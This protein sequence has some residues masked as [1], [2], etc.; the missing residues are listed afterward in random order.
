M[1]YAPHIDEEDDWGEEDSNCS[2]AP[3]AAGSANTRPTGS[4]FRDNKNNWR[5]ERG[6]SSSRRGSPRFEPK[7]GIDRRRQNESS[8]RRSQHGGN[9]TYMDR[10]YGYNDKRGGYG[11][12]PGGYRGRSGDRGGHVQRQYSGREGG[13]IQ[14]QRGA[15]GGGSLNPRGRA[16][17]RFYGGGAKWW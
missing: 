10:S 6:D 9:Q 17:Q 4:D 2:S 1:S 14:K 5:Y 3:V 16:R 12:S 13:R 8:Y 11:G 15:R 7:Q